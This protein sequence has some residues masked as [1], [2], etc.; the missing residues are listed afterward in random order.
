MPLKIDHC[1]CTGRFFESLLAQ[2]RSEGLSLP[3]LM[4]E[5]GAGRGCRSCSVYVCRSYRTGQV[6][7][8]DLVDPAE[9]PEP[10]EADRRPA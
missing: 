7:F 5:T 6:V 3:Q 8:R 2:A 10:S 1:V 9:E 4:K